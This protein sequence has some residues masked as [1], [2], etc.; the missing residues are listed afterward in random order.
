VTASSASPVWTRP[1]LRLFLAFLLF[2]GTLALYA[3]ATRNGFVNYDDPDYVTKNVHVLQGLTRPNLAWAFSTSNPAGNWH[4]LTWISHMTDVQWYATN[5]A[6]HHLTNILLHSLDVALLFLLLEFATGMTWRSAAVAVLFAVH[7]LNVESVAW[8]A[9]RKAVLSVLF[10]LLALWAYGR[11]VRKPGVGRYACVA[12]FFSLALMAKIMVVTLPFALLLLDYWPLRR[13]QPPAE[14]TRPRA[15]LP[16]FLSLVREKIPLFLLAAAGAYLTVLAQRKASSVGGVLALPLTWRVKNA[17]YSYV[18]Y[19]R[20]AI[21]P[22]RLAVFYPHPENSLT[23]TK[24]FA[25]AVMLIA[26]SALVWRFRKKGYLLT[27]WLWFLGT[28]FPMVGIVQSGRQGM[29]DRYAYIPLLGIFL[30]V[31]W[32]MADWARNLQLKQGL[33]VAIF[34]IAASPYAYWTRKQIGYW[35]DSYTLFS[36]AI[37]VTVNNGIAENNLGAA[38]LERGQAPLAAVH[39][40]AATRLIPGLASAHYNLGVILQMQGRREEASRQYRLAIADSSDP[41]EAAQAHNNLGILALQSNQPA[42]ALTELSAAIALN[43]DEQNS[44]I[45]RGMVELQFWNVDAAIADFL[46][47][48]AIAPS[49]LAYFNLG[50]ALEMKGDFPR[51]ENAYANALQLAPGMTGAQSSLQALRMKMN[52]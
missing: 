22:V 3:P 21:W 47:A 39:F 19:L 24:A 5:A 37:E 49:P 15:S 50:R 25:G 18:A 34:L 29:A 10:F 14:P 17:A 46:R 45:G 35:K 13:F 44:F 48:V 1:R 31:I 38:L 23:W 11:Y 27:G 9:E 43:P 30:A 28:L 6:G 4:P 33:L 26:I 40:E 2:V 8:V 36:H 42:D 12:I 20:D 32:L 52:K 7:P 41:I 51:A 16:T